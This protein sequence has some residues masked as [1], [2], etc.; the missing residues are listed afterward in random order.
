MMSTVTNCE[1]SPIQNNDTI[2]SKRRNRR[3]YSLLSL[4]QIFVLSV[5]VAIVSNKRNV[6]NAQDPNFIQIPSNCTIDEAVFVE[7]K[8]VNCSL[9]DSSVLQYECGCQDIYYYVIYS[10]QLGDI[11]PYYLD[12]GGINDYRYHSSEAPVDREERSCK[13]TERAEPKWNP[14]D[15]TQCWMPSKP[16]RDLRTQY[17]CGNTECI[18]VFPPEFDKNED[19]SSFDKGV[20]MTGA[21]LFGLSLPIIAMSL[22]VSR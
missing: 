19:E 8:Q 12:T 21:A 2:Y 10:P 9:E 5:L 1:T 6:V 18:K 14:G 3:A 13:N 16:G 7:S 15:K 4:C 17:R 22:S 11:D 20:W